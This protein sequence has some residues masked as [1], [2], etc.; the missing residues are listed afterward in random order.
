MLTCSFFFFFFSF[1]LPRPGTD[2]SFYFIFHIKYDYFFVPKATCRSHVSVLI[3]YVGNTQQDLLSVGWCL[4]KARRIN[5]LT[6]CSR[7]T[8]VMRLE[9]AGARGGGW[10]QSGAG[11]VPAPPN[12]TSLC[13]QTPD[14]PLRHTSEEACH[15][16]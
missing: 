6:S 11:R 7:G 1:C 10:G 9:R 3:I 5:I 12:L 2:G 8:F 14:S 15:G 4:N 16:N 13:F